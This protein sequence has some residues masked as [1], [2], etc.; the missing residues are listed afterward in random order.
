MVSPCFISHLE[1]G[2]A[3]FLT[4][5]LLILNFSHKKRHSFEVSDIAVL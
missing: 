3:D 2:R 1:L 5:L 4:L